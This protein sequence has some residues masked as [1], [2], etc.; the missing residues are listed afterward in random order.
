MGDVLNTT[1]PVPVDAALEPVPPLEVGSTPLIPTLRVPED[2]TGP[3]DVV[4]KE[5]DEEMLTEVTVPVPGVDGVCQDREVPLEVRT[6]P[7]VPTVDRPVPPLVV[8]R[9]PLIPTLRVPTPVIP[10]PDAVMKE[11]EEEKPTFV[12]VPVPGLV[13]SKEVPLEVRTV[14]LAPT[15]VRPVPPL[16][17]PNVPMLSVKT[18]DVTMVSPVTVMK[19]SEDVSPTEET[20]P[21]PPAPGGVCQ[22]IA[23]APL[24]VRT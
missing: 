18:P 13:H 17:V 11:L 1:P 3:P 5:L 16:A 2:V 6:W 4:I 12:T 7:V 23:P 22:V 24:V 19:G 14:P 9:A 15:V 10:P 8:G 20:P 21:P